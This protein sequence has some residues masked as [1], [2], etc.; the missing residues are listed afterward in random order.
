[1]RNKYIYIVSFGSVEERLLIATAI[2][3]KSVFGIETRIAF[4][5]SELKFGYNPFRNQF[6]AGTILN[7]L[8]TLKYPSMLRIIAIVDFDIYEEGLNFVFG[9]A[10]Y[11]GCCA[12]VSIYRLKNPE[13]SILFERT[14]K[15][16]NH[17][18]GHT[19]GLRHCENMSCVMSF[20]NS[21][22]D[23]DRKSRNFCE[24]C[25]SVLARKLKEYV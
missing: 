14:F 22:F 15:E 23:V 24:R 3:V 20:S 8:S 9:E 5:S 11:N 7:F 16:V 25:L 10:R 21:I 2:N 6:H 18:L 13:E 19:F 4:V 12:V 17:E 1:M